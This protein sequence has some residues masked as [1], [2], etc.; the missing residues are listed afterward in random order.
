MAYLTLAHRYARM[1]RRVANRLIGLCFSIVDDS[2][3]FQGNLSWWGF[4]C[5]NQGQLAAAFSVESWRTELAYSVC[6]RRSVLM[7][8]AGQPARSLQC[9]SFIVALYSW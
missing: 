3:I 7:Y 5:P 6:L 8:M 4:V 2:E 1:A 9:P